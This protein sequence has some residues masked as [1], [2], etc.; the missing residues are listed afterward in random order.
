MAEGSNT[1][2][3]L[4]P[5]NQFRPFFESL[6]TS[7]REIY[8][9][10][11]DGYCRQSAEIYL[12]DLPGW[13]YDG[14][15]NLIHCMKDEIPELYF[16][17]FNSGV[18]RA[19]QARHGLTDAK[20]I[21]QYLFTSDEA[22]SIEVEMSARAK[23]VLAGVEGRSSS[24]KAEMIHDWLITRY[25]YDKPDRRYTHE[26]PGAMLYGIS[27]CEGVAKAFKWLCD[28]CGVRCYVCVGRTGEKYKQGLDDGWHAWNIV[29][30]GTPRKKVWRHVD[31]T[32]D[33]GRSRENK[34]LR[35]DYFGLSDRVIRV[36]H[37]L[38][39]HSFYPHCK[40][41]SDWYASH[42]LYAHDPSS[43]GAIMQKVFESKRKRIA[44]RIPIQLEEMR[45]KACP[46]VWES[47]RKVSVGLSGFT[48]QLDPDTGIC[49]FTFH[50][51]SSESG[52]WL[53]KSTAS[54]STRR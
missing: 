10:I 31:V 34:M 29:D 30:F 4:I 9:T 14:L 37:E 5:R 23:S 46:V 22:K 52:G 8:A 38:G 36:D 45:E 20:Y 6:D 25:R 40:T 21:P 54:R 39:V 47:A 24:D 26:A 53:M 11:L 13:E 33:A 15:W 3:S 7:A 17:R 28:R 18:V 48:T 1:I 16:V 27:V 50:Y 35:Y 43:F 12:G 32:W 2:S 49:Q 42:G 51:K 41:S 19:F 44:V